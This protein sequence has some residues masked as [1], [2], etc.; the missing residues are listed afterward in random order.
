LNLCIQK[1]THLYIRR[2]IHVDV[3]YAQK[4]KQIKV[5]FDTTASS[6]L[7]TR[8]CSSIACYYIY[9]TNTLTPQF[10][11]GGDRFDVAQR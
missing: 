6:Q 7:T 11:F 10:T 4:R 8:A 2:P 1:I 3:G 9:K 5:L